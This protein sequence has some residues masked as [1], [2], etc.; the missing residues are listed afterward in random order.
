L[1]Y[2]KKRQLVKQGYNQCA[3]NYVENRDLFK[4]QKHLEDLAKKLTPGASI[5]D[6]GC[7]SG[8]PI[9]K[10][11]LGKGFKVTGIDISE[12]MIKLARN[13][14]PGAKYLVQDMSEVDFP[15]NS[16]NAVVSFYAIFHIP[17]EKHLSLLK[18]IH[19]LLKTNGCLLITMGS[20]DWEGTEDDFHGAKMFWSHYNKDKN[21]ELVKEAGFQI[22]DNI[23]DTS[24]GERHLVI[25]AKKHS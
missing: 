6:L 24:G 9:D 15:P 12:E 8:V 16:F 19:T 22:I 13:N 7:G 2:M 4:N 1:E 17:R 25:F 5:L 23:I 21:V 18:K 11:L 10:F 14:F 3:K 20:S